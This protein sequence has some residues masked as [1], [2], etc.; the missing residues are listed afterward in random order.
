ME[1]C[2]H[3]II[4]GKH[5]TIFLLNVN[6]YEIIKLLL[7]MQKTCFRNC[8]LIVLRTILRVKLH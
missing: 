4:Y 1:L 6:W 8:L 7:C 5:Y 3:K 2:L